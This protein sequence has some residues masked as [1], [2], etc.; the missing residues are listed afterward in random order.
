V[1]YQNQEK[2]KERRKKENIQLKRI[3]FFKPL[4]AF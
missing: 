1:A 4:P 2:R 3:F